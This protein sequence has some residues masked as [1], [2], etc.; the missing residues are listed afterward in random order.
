MLFFFAYRKVT[1]RAVVPLVTSLLFIIMRVCLYV[2]L[3]VYI[4]VSESTAFI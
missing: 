1:F 3:R 4:F 2:G